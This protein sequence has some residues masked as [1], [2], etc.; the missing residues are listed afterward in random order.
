MLFGEAE[1]IMDKSI[2]DSVWQESWE[3]YY[4][5]GG[6]NDPTYCIIKFI[7]K[8]FKY[9]NVENGEYKKIE[10]RI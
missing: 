3:E 9:Y 4:P 10:D 1:I 7:P 5:N 2:K 6:K 8:N